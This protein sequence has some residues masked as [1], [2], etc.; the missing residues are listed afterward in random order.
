[1]GPT[2]NS[3]GAEG[4]VKHNPKSNLKNA[5]AE[6]RGKTGSESKCSGGINFRNNRVPLR[7]HMPGFNFGGVGH[8]RCG[9]VGLSAVRGLTRIGG[10][11]GINIGSF[12][13]TKFVSSGRLMGMLNGKALA[14]GLS[15]RT[16]TFSGDTV[17]TVRT[18]N[19]AM[20]GL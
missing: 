17:T 16:R 5:S 3:A 1:M 7:H 6:N 2:R 15:M 9:T 20:M 19:K 14:A 13:R 18:M 12:V 8:I 11:R 10:L 4:E